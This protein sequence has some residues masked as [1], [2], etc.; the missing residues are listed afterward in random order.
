MFYLVEIWFKNHNTIL[1]RKI[2]VYNYIISENYIFNN[3][4]IKTS[5]R[6]FLIHVKKIKYDPP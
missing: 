6:K 2:V 3:D 1:I 4:A 5:S